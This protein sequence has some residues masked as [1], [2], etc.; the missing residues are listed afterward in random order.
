MVEYDA[1]DLQ[2]LRW[3]RNNDQ[4]GVGVYVPDQD[5]CPRTVVV[6]VPMTPG[7]MTDLA[8]DLLETARQMDPGAAYS[9]RV[10]YPRD[11]TPEDE[12]ILA[13][14]LGRCRED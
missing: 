13:Y 2:V 1:S 5:G 11:L 7:E 14:M 9:A 12:A 8:L 6:Q 4:A 10:T 3:Q